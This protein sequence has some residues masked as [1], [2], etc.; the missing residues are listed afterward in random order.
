[1]CTA[2]LMQRV[3]FVS[4]GVVGVWALGLL[5]PGVVCSLLAGDGCVLRTVA[6]RSSWSTCYMCVV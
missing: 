3:C 2:V 1:M 4:V 6:I 5:V